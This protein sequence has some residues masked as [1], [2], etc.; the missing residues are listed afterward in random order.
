ME[1]AFSYLSL[2]RLFFLVSN[3]L[4]LSCLSNVL[5]RKFPTLRSFGFILY[6]IITFLYPEYLY[7]YDVG[8]LYT[9]RSEANKTLDFLRLETLKDPINTNYSC[10]YGSCTAILRLSVRAYAK[11]AAAEREIGGLRRSVAAASFLGI[12]RTAAYRGSGGDKEEVVYAS[13]HCTNS[14]GGIARW[15]AKRQL[16]N[17]AGNTTQEE[18]TPSHTTSFPRHNHEF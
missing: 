1:T 11:H 10:A 9:A 17:S 15:I 6:I 3:I 16:G 4:I 13:L 12:T 8:T 18:L 5:G 7:R 14:W 2:F